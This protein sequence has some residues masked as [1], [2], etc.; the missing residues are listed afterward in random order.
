MTSLLKK[1][2]K[3]NND[4]IPAKYF[5]K[6]SLNYNSNQP[7]FVATKPN[8]CWERERERER[9]RTTKV[10]VIITEGRGLR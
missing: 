4:F 10:E 6:M 9:E 3:K 5:A 1:E 2:E 7:L 8:R